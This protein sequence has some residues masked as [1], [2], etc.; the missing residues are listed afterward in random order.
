M[1]RHE[2]RILN[3]L[4]PEPGAFYLFDRGYLDFARLH[5][6]HQA[7]SSESE[8]DFAHRQLVLL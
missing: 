6:F 2:V 5:N 3:A 1:A 7:C 8:C 4:T